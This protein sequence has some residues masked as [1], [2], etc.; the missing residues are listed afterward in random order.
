MNLKV[1]YTQKQEKINKYND[2]INFTCHGKP[3]KKEFT[4][5]QIRSPEKFMAD[6]INFLLRKDEVIQEIRNE[7]IEQTNKTFLPCPV[8]SEVIFK[9]ILENKK[10]S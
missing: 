7:I 8:I 5:S 6:N 4:S 1:N 2:E 10:N 3:N 9:F